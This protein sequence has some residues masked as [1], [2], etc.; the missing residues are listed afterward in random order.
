MNNRSG[1]RVRADL[2]RKLTTLTDQIH[3][4]MERMRIRILAE[5]SEAHDDDRPTELAAFESF[6]HALYAAE[7]VPVLGM[8]FLP[9]PTA[10]PNTKVRW[11]YNSGK[12]PDGRASLRPLTVGL[13][14]EAMDFY[15]A[16][17]TEWWQNG[18]NSDEP[19]V[20]GPF[21]DISGT[22]AYVVTFAQSVRIE[23]HLIGVVAADVTVATLQS[24][25]QNDLLDM[26]RPTSVITREGMVIATNAGALLGGAVVSS[27]IKDDQRSRIDGTSWL[28]SSGR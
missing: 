27:T 2:T 28:L 20:S 3:S 6:V 24:L 26:P 22:N 13:K 15:D 23:G 10:L 5:A 4:L 11:W 1:K 16:T 25:C 18:A 9:N 19:V 12:F 21:V 14:P 7:A 17:S 8:G